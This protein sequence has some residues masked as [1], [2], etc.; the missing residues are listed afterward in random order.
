MFQLQAPP[1]RCLRCVPLAGVTLIVMGSQI[2]SQMAGGGPRHLEGTGSGGL[3][4]P[5]WPPPSAPPSHLGL[6]L[7]S[8]NHTGTLA[9]TGASWLRPWAMV[10]ARGRPSSQLPQRNPLHSVR[11]GLPS[12][13]NRRG[14]KY[15]LLGLQKGSQAKCE[16]VSESPEETSRP[17]QKFYL[18]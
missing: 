4:T 13:R 15:S 17:F 12:Q 3:E 11:R 16:E 9:T 14:S 8:G 6:R 5:K 18:W 1:A 10:E 2:L 7:Q